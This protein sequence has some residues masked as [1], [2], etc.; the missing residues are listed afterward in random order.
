MCEG[1]AHTVADMCEG[2]THAVADMCE[3]VVHAMANMWEGVVHAMAKLRAWLM[4]WP[5]SDSM[6]LLA[7]VIPE[8]LVL[9]YS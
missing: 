7:I 3:G 1:V 4:R 5:K 9:F 8:R 2:V 6:C